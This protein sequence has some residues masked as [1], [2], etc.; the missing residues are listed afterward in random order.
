MSISI[1]ISRTTAH[2][3]QETLLFARATSAQQ[4]ARI[5]RGHSP[6][7]I[8]NSFIRDLRTAGEATVDAG[9]VLIG[10]WVEC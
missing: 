4:A 2:G 9:Q 5:V 10:A 8:N 6:R 7:P 3:D 1:N